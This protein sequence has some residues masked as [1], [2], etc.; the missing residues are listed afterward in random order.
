MSKYYY[1]SI[2][3]SDILASSTNRDITINSITLFNSFPCYTN[4]LTNEIDADKNK[5]DIYKPN[6]FGY[7]VKKDTIYYD[8]SIL[9][10]AYYVDYTSPYNTDKELLPPSVFDASKYTIK[11]RAICIGGG[12]GG[13]GGTSFQRFFGTSYNGDG[14][15]SGGKGTISVSDITNYDKTTNNYYYNV[16]N[17]GSGGRGGTYFEEVI[18]DDGGNQVG[19]NIIYSDDAGS[20]IAGTKSIVYSITKIG[21]TNTTIKEAAGGAGSVTVITNVNSGGSA[22]TNTGYTS[23]AG[24]SAGGNAG[25]SGKGGQGGINTHLE[26]YGGDNGIAGFIRIIW[27]IT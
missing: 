9:G 6:D 22:K 24:I 2:A 26:G 1:N 12:G 15:L 14:G 13:S 19:T 4:K 5:N 20:G 10:T 16:G 11:F 25:S 3:I 23:S 17:S 27:Y 8:L 7:K 18:T 21:S